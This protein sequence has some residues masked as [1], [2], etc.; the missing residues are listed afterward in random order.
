MA[1]QDKV[2]KDLKR[3]NDKLDEQRMF[4]EARE[5]SL[6]YR[7]AELIKSIKNIHRHVLAIVGASEGDQLVLAECNLID[8][9]IQRCLKYYQGE[10]EDG[11][12]KGSIW[13]I[14]IW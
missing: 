1:N 2:I 4:A 9:E 11:N 3:R 6:G 14:Q 8:D 13:W 12:I 5:H 10:K 7:N